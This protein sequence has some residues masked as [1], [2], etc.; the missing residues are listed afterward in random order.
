MEHVRKQF[1]ENRVAKIHEP[2][3]W[4]HF[5]GRENPVDI[6]SR[7]LGASALTST[8]FWLDG[9]DWLYHKNEPC[10]DEEDGHEILVPSYNPQHA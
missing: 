1:V 7:G 3:N 4:K 6:Q 9:P 8:A 5:P 10:V 2:Q